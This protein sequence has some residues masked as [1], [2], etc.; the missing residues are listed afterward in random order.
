MKIN[1]VA[2]LLDMTREEV[3]ITISDGIELPKSK[4]KPARKKNRMKTS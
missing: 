4:Q 3:K 1:E 2:K